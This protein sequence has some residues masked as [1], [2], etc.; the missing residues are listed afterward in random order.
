M[1]FQFQCADYMFS[2]SIF[3]HPRRAEKTRWSRSSSFPTKN[4]PV[5]PFSFQFRASSN[6]SMVF[7]R[8][9]SGS[10]VH[11]QK[12]RQDITHRPKVVLFHIICVNSSCMI[13]SCCEM[14]CSAV[15]HRVAWCAVLWRLGLQEVV[16]CS[17]FDGLL[18]D[19]RYIGS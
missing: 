15:Q 12:H 10:R 11:K 13:T 8:R 6:E 7:P 1:L 2:S 19:G 5:S 14:W 18:G 17:V 16:V 3:S 9:V 4:I